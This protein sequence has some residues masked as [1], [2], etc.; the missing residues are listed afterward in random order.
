MDDLKKT[1]TSKLI[2]QT[3]FHD[4][5]QM[6]L[7]YHLSRPI[8]SFD[9]LWSLLVAWA[10]TFDR[11]C[12]SSTANKLTAR[13]VLMSFCALEQEEHCQGYRISLHSLILFLFWPNCQTDFLR[14]QYPL[15]WFTLVYSETVVRFLGK[16][17]WSKCK[18]KIIIDQWWFMMSH[19]TNHLCLFI[20]FV[21]YFASNIR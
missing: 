13:P 6:P 20:I 1:V 17:T 4:D 7:L 8:F 14:T 11:L 3:F 9:C 15:L 10:C 21:I 2:V 12:K 18:F 5:V 16:T 19:S